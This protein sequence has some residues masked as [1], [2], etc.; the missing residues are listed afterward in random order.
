MELAIWLLDGEGCTYTGISTR[1]CWQMA[2]RDT[3][4]IFT[5]RA[6]MIDV[7][8]GSAKINLGRSFAKMMPCPQLAHQETCNFVCI[9]AT[10]TLRIL[11][12]YV[13]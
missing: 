3:E 5:R 9:T 6:N 13:P 11:T 10:K 8:R 4:D 1:S 12:P 7:V 2:S